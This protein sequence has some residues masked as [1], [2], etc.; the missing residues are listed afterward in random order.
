MLDKI[1]LSFNCILSLGMDGS[2]VNLAFK[3]KL[4]L[5]LEKHK[6]T[7]VD[8]GTCPLHIASNA[9]REGLK[10]L[11][12]ELDIDLDQI[13]LDLFGFFKYS[14][15][16]IAEYFDVTEFTLIESRRMLKSEFWNSFQI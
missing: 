4:E 11:T 10:T 12:I 7:L 8:V 9:F 2:R 3:S 5:D 6:K 16:R 13:V 15:K 1:Q 14:T